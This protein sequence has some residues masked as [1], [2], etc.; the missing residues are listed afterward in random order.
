MSMLRW[1]FLTT[2]LPLRPREQLGEKMFQGSVV[3]INIAPAAENALAAVEQARAVPGKGLEG[4]RYF[5][6]AGTGNRVFRGSS[7]TQH[8][9]ARCSVESSGGA[10]VSNWGDQGSRLEAVRTLL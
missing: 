8:R 7:A 1:R 2:R 5:N 4:D 6:Q 9:H 3:S 10:R